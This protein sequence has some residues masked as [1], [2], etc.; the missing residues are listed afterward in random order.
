MGLLQCGYL[1]FTTLRNVYRFV[2]TKPLNTK[3]SPDHHCQTVTFHIILENLLWQE[4][5]LDYTTCPRIVPVPR[6][7]PYRQDN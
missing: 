4:T 3:L 2:H 6:T 7:K 5:A 1:P